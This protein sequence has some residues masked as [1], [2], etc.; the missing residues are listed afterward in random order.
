LRVYI[1]TARGL[2]IGCLGGFVYII[3]NLVLPSSSPPLSPLFH[4]KPVWLSE[5]VAGIMLSRAREHL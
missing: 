5:V 3:Y 1:W 2:T 4:A